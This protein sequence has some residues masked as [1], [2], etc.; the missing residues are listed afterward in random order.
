MLK[1][2]AETKSNWKS[3]WKKS[4]YCVLVTCFGTYR[5]CRMHI[6][7]MHGHSMKCVFIHDQTSTDCSVGEELVEKQLRL[8]E[9]VKKSKMY[10]V[11]EGWK[12]KTWHTAAGS[13]SER[14]N[15]MRNISY[16][17]LETFKILAKTLGSS[18]KPS[19]GNVSKTS[20]LIKSKLYSVKLFF[21]SR[22]S[23]WERANR[24]KRDPSWT[25]LWDL[26]AKTHT[27]KV[28]PCLWCN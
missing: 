13:Y 1:M 28:H 18:L 26:C 16:G 22:W 5:M 23:K 21:T 10:R 3:L 7:R 9:Q 6:C 4:S 12:K 11:F 19:T 17:A 24:C 8:P 25:G 27:P 15:S 20:D 14:E 2:T